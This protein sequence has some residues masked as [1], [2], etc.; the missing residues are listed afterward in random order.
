MRLRRLREGADVS[1]LREMYHGSI[2]GDW[3]GDH[4]A[5][6]VAHDAEGLAAFCG[7]K[8]L[9][10]TVALSSA[11]VAPRARGQNLQRRMIRCRLRWGMRLGAT[12]ATTYVYVLNY[13]SLTNLLLEGF[14]FHKT[15]GEFHYLRLPLQE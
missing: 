12:L 15:N 2:E 6:W 5:F 10:N 4:Q 8:L 9:G 14:R 1:A 3:P 11:V 13:P 7:A